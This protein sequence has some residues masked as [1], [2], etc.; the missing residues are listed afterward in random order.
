VE[1]FYGTKPPVSRIRSTAD[2]HFQTA[3]VGHLG[4]NFVGDIDGDGFNDLATF[5]SDAVV[6][7]GTGS[8]LTLLH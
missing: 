6:G 1:L 5:D 2:G 7:G 4:V 3:D 8:A